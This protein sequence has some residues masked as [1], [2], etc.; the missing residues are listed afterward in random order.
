MKTYTVEYVKAS[1][2]MNGEPLPVTYMIGH[3]ERLVG[4]AY[5]VSR[6]DFLHEL[7]KMFSEREAYDRSYGLHGAYDLRVVCNAVED[8]PRSVQF[9]DVNN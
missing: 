1:D 7:L 5:L 2:V 4:E 9:V 6:T 3:G 8:L